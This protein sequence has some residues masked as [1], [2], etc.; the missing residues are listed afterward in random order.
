MGIIM[1]LLK[2]K[3]YYYSISYSMHYELAVAWS[4][5]RFSRSSD[6]KNQASRGSRGR[7]TVV[8]RSNNQAVAVCVN[9][10]KSI[11]LTT[12]VSCTLKR[13]AFDMSVCVRPCMTTLCTCVRECNILHI[14]HSTCCR[15]TLYQIWERDRFPHLSSI[16][17]IKDTSNV[18]YCV[19]ELMQQR[20]TVCGRCPWTTRGQCNGGQP[21]S[22]NLARICHG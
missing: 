11:G 19:P 15:S 16:T 14:V 6:K 13:R 12:L 7:T 4:W 18:L 1:Q 5:T 21:D 9:R 3:P 17:A 20:D 2:N 10:W 8:S 22:T